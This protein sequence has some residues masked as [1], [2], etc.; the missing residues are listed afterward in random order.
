VVAYRFCRP[1]DLPLLARA[2]NLC[3]RVH[4]PHLPETTVESLQR[5]ARELDLWASN[6]LVALEGE[7]P[8]AVLIGTRRPQEVL[9]LRLGV[10]PGH[11]RCG[12]AR[13]LLTSLSRKLGVLGPDRMVAEVPVRWPAAVACLKSVGYAEEGRYRDHRWQP[14]TV[15]PVPEGLVIPVSFRELAD[16]EALTVQEGVAWQRQRAT[17]EKRQ[18]ALSGVAVATP[19]RIESYLLFE[20]TEQGVRVL[21]Q[22]AADPGH[23]PLLFGILFRHLAAA[24]GGPV[25]LPRLAPSEADS[26]LLADLGFVAGEAT[27]RLV[28]RAAPE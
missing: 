17:L 23:S 25:L 9:M 7:E 19:D 27:L 16:S 11:Q 18:E 22:G 24:Y 12:H 13:H 26:G 21:A 2:V 10:R 14:E 3:W 1:D 15:E 5:E 28:A 8:V 20:D 6:C 4:F